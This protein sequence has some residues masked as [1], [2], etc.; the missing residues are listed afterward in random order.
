MTDRSTNKLLR[1][2]TAEQKKLNIVGRD[3]DWNTRVYWCAPYTTW[4][5]GWLATAQ[6]QTPATTWR[7]TSAWWLTGLGEPNRIGHSQSLLSRDSNGHLV[8]LVW[9]DTRADE[10]LFEDVTAVALSYFI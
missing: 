10:W 9:N 1:G 2:A 7:F 5:A 3:L 6:A 4:H 8:R